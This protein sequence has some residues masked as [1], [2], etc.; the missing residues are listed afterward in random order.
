MK[1]S[2]QIFAIGLTTLLLF[3]GMRVTLNYGYYHIDTIGF[4]EAFCVNQDKPELKCN[5]KCHLKKVSKS[6]D[7]DQKTP[8]SIVD[9]KELL[10]FTNTMETIV[11]QQKIRL[12]K[13]NPS[14]YQNLYSFHNI[15]DCFHPPKV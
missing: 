9:F 14:T 11:F 10:L 2:T 3:N 12:K 13:Q 4:I 1:L 5:G 7:K 15:N 6:Q 8:E